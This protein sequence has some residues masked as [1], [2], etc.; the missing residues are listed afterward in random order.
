[1]RDRAAQEGDLALA[2]QHHVGHEARAAMKM[3]RVFLARTETP[4]P[5]FVTLLRNRHS[6]ARARVRLRQGGC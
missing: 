3:A 4:M 6:E 1:M 2:R 5:C